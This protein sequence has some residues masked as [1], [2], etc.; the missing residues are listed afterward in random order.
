MLPVGTP[1]TGTGVSRIALDA[2]VK[3][4]VGERTRL[5]ALNIVPL[6]IVSVWTAPTESTLCWA[7]AIKEPVMKNINN[8]MTGIPALFAFPCAEMAAMVNVNLTF[9]MSLYCLKRQ[10]RSFSNN[11]NYISFRRLLNYREIKDY[12]PQRSITS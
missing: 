7:R 12:G 5:T 1:G 11:A 4:L 2:I 9:I 6:V 8:T 10:Q 3:L